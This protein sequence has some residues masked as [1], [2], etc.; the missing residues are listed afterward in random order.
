M[1]PVSL[2][3]HFVGGPA[4]QFYIAISMISFVS[5]RDYVIIATFQGKLIFKDMFIFACTMI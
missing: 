4:G 3:L 2:N 5:C 1:L